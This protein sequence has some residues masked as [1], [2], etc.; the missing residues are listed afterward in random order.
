MSIDRESPHKPLRLWPGLVAAALIVPSLL[1]PLVVEG[2]GVFGLL[3][4][5]IGVAVAL[6]WWLILSRAPWSERVAAVLVMAGVLAVVWRFVHPSIANGFMQQMPV[7]FG[8]PILALGLVVWAVAFRRRFS[9]AARFVSM[10]ACVTLAGS[11]LTLVRTG[12]ITGDADSDLHWRWTPTAEERLLAAAA[13][14]LT[15]IGASPAPAASAP[16]APDPPARDAPVAPEAPGSAGAS[17]RP[18]TGADMG[19]SAAQARSHPPAPAVSADWPGF[20]G[21]ERDSVV[22]GVQ[23]ETDWSRHPPAE[24]WRRPVGP[25]WS[26]FAVGGDLVYTQEQRGENEVVSCYRLSTGAPV[27]RHDDAVRFYESNG[28]AGPRAT[29]T[30]HGGRVYTMGATGIVNALDA[31]SGSV[32]WSRNAATDTAKT[33]PD[34]GLAGSPLVIGDLVIVAV[35]GQLAAYD[36]R[37][38]DPRWMGQPGGG[39]YSSP[40]LA[41]IAGVPQVLLLRGARTL[42]VAPADGALLWEHSWQPAVSIVQPALAAN[43]DVLIASGDAM[44]GLGMRRLS[45]AHGSTGWTVEERW[46]SR[47]LKPYFNDFV[48]HEGHAYGFDGSILAAVNLDDGTR[49]WKGG[50]YGHGQLVL[51][52]DQ[53]LLL[54]LSEDGELALVSA[55]PDRF[56]EIAR[57]PALEGKTWN[58]P[59]LVGDVLLVRNGEEM[60]AFRV[61]LAAR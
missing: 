57:I 60:A 52:P 44:G 22:R 21:P 17:A 43:N 53:D 34:W 23:I 9:G 59:V 45:V 7:V 41:T 4:G 36:V 6:M 1:V 33:I 40:H 27:W 31:A 12:G 58:H 54:V 14:P 20:R 55:T 11:V 8:T 3:G 24:L 19:A 48:V 29:P 15:G 5:A 26:S 56:T 30:L 50:R 46:T 10:A 32:V 37:T 47:G 28:G 38:G 2:T 49:A 51:L 25:G 35:A 61:S 39:G 16:P 18:P 13:G 42:S